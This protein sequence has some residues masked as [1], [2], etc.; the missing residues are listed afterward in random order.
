VYDWL[1]SRSPL[2]DF[3]RPPG[4]KQESADRRC[5]HCR[6]RASPGGDWLLLFLEEQGKEEA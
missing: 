4:S 5:R 3:S 2:F 6:R 1:A